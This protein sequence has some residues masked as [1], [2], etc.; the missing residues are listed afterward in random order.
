MRSFPMQLSD[1]RNFPPSN[2]DGEAHTRLPESKNIFYA[3]VSPHENPGPPY[4]GGAHPPDG[5]EK[6]HDADLGLADRIRGLPPGLRVLR[7]RDGGDRVQVQDSG[8]H[9]MISVFWEFT[10]IRSLGTD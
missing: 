4:S 7:G 8:P 10:G 9:R 5:L 3:K 6:L 1:A 2:T